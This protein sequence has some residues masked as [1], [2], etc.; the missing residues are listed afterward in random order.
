[1]SSV[2]AARREL[3]LV[4]RDIRDI[5]FQNLHIPLMCGDRLDPATPQ[6]LMLE[7]GLDALKHLRERKKRLVESIGAN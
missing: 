2:G 4:E 5:E 3:R 6:A 1:M 7:K